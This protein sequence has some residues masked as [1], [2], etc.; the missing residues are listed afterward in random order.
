MWTPD[1]PHLYDL[2]VVIS[3][4]K[5]NVVDI[6]TDRT[7]YRTV[8]VKGEED[9]L[10]FPAVLFMP[11]GSLVLYGQP[12][13]GVVMIKVTEAAKNKLVRFIHQR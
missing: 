8:E 3:D 1:T 2:E 11:L 9:L 12:Q 5:G 13:E 6:W 7:G 10:G 4:K